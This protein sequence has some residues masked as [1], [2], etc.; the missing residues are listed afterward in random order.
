MAKKKARTIRFLVFP[1]GERREI[2]GETGKYWLCGETQFRKARALEIVEE[3]AEEKP[4]AERGE[5][6]ENE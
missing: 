3:K 2:T 5:E 1:D 6:G 4:D